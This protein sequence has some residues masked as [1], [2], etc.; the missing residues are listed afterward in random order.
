MKRL[1]DWKHRLAAFVREREHAPFVW[2][3]QDCALFT[4]DAIRVMT[5]VDVAAELRG[6]D[7]ARGAVKAL[8]DY[9]VRRDVEVPAWKVHLPS[10]L[11]T[12][13]TRIALEHRALRITPTSVRPG[14]I[15]LAKVA[16]PK[17]SVALSLIGLD[18][19][20]L[21]AGPDGIF[22]GERNAVAMAWRIG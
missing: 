4:C 13:A 18:G 20:L 16:T 10:L 22:R 2:G 5:D 19:K 17:S 3:R 14:D 8:V 21:S 9:L 12:V 6:Y 1:P 7:C 15:T 11:A